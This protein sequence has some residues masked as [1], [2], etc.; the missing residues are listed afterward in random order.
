MFKKWLRKFGAWFGRH[1]RN[2]GE[3]LESKRHEVLG[4]DLT[5]EFQHL[6]DDRSA[7]LEHAKMRAI[8]WETHR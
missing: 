6:V 7:Q 1:L 8:Y 2:R 5:K 3:K 4:N